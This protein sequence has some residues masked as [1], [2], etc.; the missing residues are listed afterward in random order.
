MCSLCTDK[1]KLLLCGWA[2]DYKRGSESIIC[3]SINLM[4]TQYPVMLSPPLL[5]RCLGIARG[6]CIEL[7][8]V[9]WRHTMHVDSRQQSQLSTLLH[10]LRL[11]SSVAE[12]QCFALHWYPGH[13]AHTHRCSCWVVVHIWSCGAYTCVSRMDSKCLH[14]AYLILPSCA[15]KWP[16]FSMSQFLHV[17]E[18]WYQYQCCLCF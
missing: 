3:Q 4:N 15:D 11:V 14:K 7:W 17:I 6:H 12:L 13:C 5:P 1:W 2:V 10:W 18:M 9:F 16:W 8:R